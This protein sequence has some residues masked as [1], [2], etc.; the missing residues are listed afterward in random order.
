MP[1]GDRK[2]IPENRKAIHA[3][4][5]DKVA[6]TIRARPDLTHEQIADMHGVSMWV[7]GK[8]SRRSGIRR[9]ETDPMKPLVCK[10]VQI[11]DRQ[12]AA[13]MGLKLEQ[14]FERKGK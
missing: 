7:V 13:R 14:Y 6:E 5:Y 9:R 10:G 12:M 2:Y 3:S 11:D 4:T 1:T 8:A